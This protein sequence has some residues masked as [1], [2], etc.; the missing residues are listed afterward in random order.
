[1]KR[2][3]FWDPW[4]FRELWFLHTDERGFLLNV[5]TGHRNSVPTLLLVSK[6]GKILLITGD[7]QG[8]KSKRLQKFLPSQKSNPSSIGTVLVL[9]P[10]YPWPASGAALFAPAIVA[11]IPW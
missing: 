11:G 5:N 1:M 6:A 2:N 7:E 9:V 4:L 3:D 8:A 10:G